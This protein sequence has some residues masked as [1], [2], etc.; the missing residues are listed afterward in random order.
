ML[1]PFVEKQLHLL[2]ASLM[3]SK[4]RFVEEY[5]RFLQWSIKNI[6]IDNYVEYESWKVQLTKLCDNAER[7]LNNYRS[8]Y[9]R[10][11]A[12]RDYIYSEDFQRD[13]GNVA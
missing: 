12:Y 13:N 6:P 5:E 8:A 9:I 11:Y 1:T 10:Y 2:Y 4:T 3:N 7:A